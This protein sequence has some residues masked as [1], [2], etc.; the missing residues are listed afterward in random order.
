MIKDILVEK[1]MSIYEL[2]KQS[3][4]P[5]STLNDLVNGKKNIENCSVKLLKTLADLFGMS[6]DCFYNECHVYTVSGF[7]AFKK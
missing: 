3:G 1:G 2:S 4:I 7:E 5:Y 6:L